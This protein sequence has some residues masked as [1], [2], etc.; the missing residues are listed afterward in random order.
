MAGELDD[1]LDR[2]GEGSE[3]SESAGGQDIDDLKL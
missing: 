2:K 3:L 1:E